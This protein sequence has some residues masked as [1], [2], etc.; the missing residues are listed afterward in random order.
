MSL[1]QY[2]L[3]LSP[4]INLQRASATIDEITKVLS[5]FSRSTT[6][7]PL[8]IPTCSCCDVGNCDT[9]L[10]WEHDRA[11]LADK[12]VLSAGTVVTLFPRFCRWVSVPC[13][14]S[15]HT[16]VYYVDRDRAGVA[17]APRSVCAYP[18]SS[19]AYFP[20]PYD[21]EQ[22]KCPSVLTVP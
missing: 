7:E 14:L 16:V 10:A 13:T 6:P 15:V 18:V 12:L 5:E 20:I 2:P 1:S 21:D 8:H 11:V 19:Y 3:S 17:R 4:H 22:D 9:K